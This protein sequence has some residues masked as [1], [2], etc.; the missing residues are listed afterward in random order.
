MPKRE[1]YFLS[2]AFAH[3]L[4]RTVQ[5]VDAL[6][7]AQNGPTQGVRYWDMQR[8]Q[9]SRLDVFKICTFTGSWSIGDS[10]TV[11]F[12]YQT[13]TPNTVVATNLFFPVASGGTSVTLKNC[14]IAKDGT[15][16][17]LVDVPLQTQAVAI[18][19]SVSTVNVLTGMSVSATLNTN[20]CSI[21]VTSN[22]QSAPV[23]VVSS[24]ASAAVVVI[25]V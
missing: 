21:S 9:S 7:L 20:N 8:P 2:P 17:F 24:T 18:V 1:R 3:E 12:K 13:A 25:G 4:K 11:A 16:W 14:A 19:Q 5:R 6:A 15:A 10:K 22:P 23:S